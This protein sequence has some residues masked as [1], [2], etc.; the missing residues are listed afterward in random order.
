MILD[1]TRFSGHLNVRLGG[2]FHGGQD[3]SIRAGV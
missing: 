2:V 3:G 1:L